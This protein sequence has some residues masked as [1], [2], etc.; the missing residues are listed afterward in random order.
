MNEP[1]TKKRGMTEGWK[2]MLQPPGK[3]NKDLIVYCM[4][5]MPV[6]CR[7]P[8]LERTMPHLSPLSM[9]SLSHLSPALVNVLF[10]CLVSTVAQKPPFGDTGLRQHS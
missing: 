7:Q 9:R 1:E 6:P 10:C 4:A 8:R 2:S 3:R 5:M